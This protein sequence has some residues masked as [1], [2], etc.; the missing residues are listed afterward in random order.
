MVTLIAALAM[1]GGRVRGVRGVTA[2]AAISRVLTAA[3]RG[4]PRGIVRVLH[5]V[6]RSEVDAADATVVV[7]RG[8]GLARLEALTARMGTGVGLDVL[9]S[10]GHALQRRHVSG[11]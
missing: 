7:V 9:Q 6:D 2:G 8:H 1:H 4:S 5:V 11:L 3:G 10:V